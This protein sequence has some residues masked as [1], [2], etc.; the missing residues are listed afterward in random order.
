MARRND[1]R[2]DGHRSGRRTRRDSRREDDLFYQLNDLFVDMI[3]DNL[4]SNRNVLGNQETGEINLFLFS[5]LS[6]DAKRRSNEIVIN[7]KR[8]DFALRMRIDINNNARS[9]RTQVDR[10]NIHEKQSENLDQYMKNASSGLDNLDS[11]SDVIEKY[12]ETYITIED[13]IADFFD[14][15]SENNYTSDEIIKVIN[16]AEI[17]YEYGE[18]IVYPTCQWNDRDGVLQWSLRYETTALIKQTIK[19]D[20]SFTGRGRR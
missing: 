15:L 7:P 17:Y 20:F 16:S 8:V 6:T 4:H 14:Y 9:R 1:R 13:G 12:C 3:E 19:N 11:V 10:S 18:F 2:N 5:R